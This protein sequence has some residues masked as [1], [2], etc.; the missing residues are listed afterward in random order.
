MIPNDIPRGTISPHYPSSF[1]SPISIKWPWRRS[2]A[3]ICRCEGFARALWCVSGSEVPLIYG[4]IPFCLNYKGCGVPI[5]YIFP[6]CW[7]SLPLPPQLSHYHCSFVSPTACE[8][9][10]NAVCPQCLKLT[11]NGHLGNACDRSQY[12]L[13]CSMMFLCCHIALCFDRE[14]VWTHFMF[15]K[16]STF[17]ILSSKS[18]RGGR[19]KFCPTTLG[20]ALG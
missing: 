3:G 8:W 16:A 10:S 13:D 2:L 6:G 5:L 15:K 14:V 17:S 1:S 20:F 7:I 9:S 4:F 19:V 18:M 12:H 11:L